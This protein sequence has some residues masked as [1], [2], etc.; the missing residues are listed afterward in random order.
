MSESPVDNS[1]LFL[2]SLK[3]PSSLTPRV[4]LLVFGTQSV[5]SA[6]QLA[7]ALPIHGILRQVKQ[8]VVL[9]V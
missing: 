2:R 1:S 5:T 8:G 6:H 4:N 3:A 9:F 7:Y